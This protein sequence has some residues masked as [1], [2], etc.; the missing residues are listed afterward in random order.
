[1]AVV[2]AT[3]ALL[4]H[5]MTWGDVDLLAEYNGRPAEWKADKPHLAHQMGMVQLAW[6]L[7]TRASMLDADCIPIPGGGWLCGGP[8]EATP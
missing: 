6:N 7:A 8:I 1:V 4:A 3:W 5:G 2:T